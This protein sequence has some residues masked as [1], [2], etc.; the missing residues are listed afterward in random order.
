MTSPVWDGDGRDPWLPARLEARLEVV[1]IE[2]DILAAVWAAL[3]DWLIQTARRVLRGATSPP[4]PDAV[5]A[6]VPAWRDA[7]DQLLR[8]E[9][10]AA[11]NTAFRRVLGADASLDQ[12]AFT[13]QYLAS[14][15]NR[16]TRVP[17]EVYD[18]VAG[19]VSAGV[20]LGE[21]IPALA[22]RV[23]NVLS[24]TGTPRWRNRAVVTA[25]TEAIG[26]MNAGRMEAFR[27]IAAD[28]PD[29]AFQKLWLATDD[30]RT[31][32][33]HDEADGQR[34]PLEGMFVVGGYE[35]AFPGDPSGPPQEV[36]QCRCTPLLVEP[37]EQIDYSNRQ[38]RRDR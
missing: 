1:R 22:A 21:G 10:L 6:R 18:L 4:S 32:P 36:I 30:R 7:V 3:S 33:S 20:N 2:E 11:L 29:I 14:V 19:Q 12:R 8:G 37:G 17:D 5:W 26:A 27:V 24:T 28:E 15:R 25:R 38:F 34:V 9:I 35:L 31:R 16:M 13:A 23:D